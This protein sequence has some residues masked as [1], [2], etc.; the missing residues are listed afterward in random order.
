MRRKKIRKINNNK[1]RII[2]IRN[3]VK[4]KGKNQMQVIKAINQM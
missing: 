3:K 1:K 4:K 2:K